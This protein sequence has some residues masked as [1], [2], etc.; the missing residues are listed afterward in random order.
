MVKW[1]PSAERMFPRSFNDAPGTGINFFAIESFHLSAPV[2]KSLSTCNCLS[3]LS[4][5]VS[6]ENNDISVLFGINRWFQQWN[7]LH[8]QNNV[9]ST[10]LWYTVKLY[11]HESCRQA[12][13]SCRFSKHHDKMWNG[14]VWSKMKSMIKT[15][16]K[17]FWW[18]PDYKFF[19]ICCVTRVNCNKI[20]ML[21]N[22]FYR[23]ILWNCG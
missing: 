18:K 1:S 11:C 8:L 7:D 21:Q 15:N 4:V 10:Y 20:I 2:G 9:L 16:G 3:I 14:S 19:R 13:A 12:T 17:M 22:T 23:N 6:S 5:T